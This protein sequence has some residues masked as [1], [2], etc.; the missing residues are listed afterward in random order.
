M[1]NNNRVR[2][3]DVGTALSVFKGTVGVAINM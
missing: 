3:I 2:E 1:G